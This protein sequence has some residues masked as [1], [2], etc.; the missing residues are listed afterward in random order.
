MTGTG[1]TSRR[2]LEQGRLL[3]VITPDSESAHPEILA[4][5]AR[6]RRAA[7]PGVVSIDSFRGDPDPT[8]TLELAGD[9]SWASL[10][11]A[12]SALPRSAAVVARTLAHLHTRGVAHGAVAAPAV[13][14]DQRGE[15]VLAGLAANAPAPPA[16]DV[17]A[18]A[19]LVLDIASR[20][21]PRTADED[22]LLVRLRRVCERAEG[23][24][25]PSASRLAG[26]LEA[27]TRTIRRPARLALTIVALGVGLIGFVWGRHPA[28]DSGSASAPTGSMVTTAPTTAPP[29]P[30]RAPATIATPP[31]TTLAS[32]TTVRPIP[33]GP[34]PTVHHDGRVWAAGQP[35]DLVVVVDWQCTERPAVMAARPGTGEV[36]LWRDWPVGGSE[37]GER[38]GVVPALTGFA[39]PPVGR[40][41]QITVTTADGIRHL[42]P[43]PRR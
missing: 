43:G 39:D 36:F 30:T 26:D 17:R 16:D 38:V 37:A 9:E 18:L 28:T 12:L 33:D 24:A 21:R 3:E 13:L 40:C 25:H 23:H 11:P 2:R 1:L 6:Y 4:L 7:V 5:A 35:G 22:R 20:A 42:R 15:P 19:R 29:T 34:T 14:V 8:L 27:S 32:T 31:P 10:P 41:G